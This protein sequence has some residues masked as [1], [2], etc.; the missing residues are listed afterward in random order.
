MPP[1]PAVAVAVA[2]TAVTVG[3]ENRLAVR[4]FPVGFVCE[5]GAVLRAVSDSRTTLLPVA[6]QTQY[7]GRRPVISDTPRTRSLQLVAVNAAS[8][9]GRLSSPETLSIRTTGSPANAIAV[10]RSAPPRQI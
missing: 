8:R 9:E 5:C 10:I 7:S 6:N 2:P 3:A 1:R 4:A